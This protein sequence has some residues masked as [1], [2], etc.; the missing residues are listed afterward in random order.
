MNKLKTYSAKLKKTNLQII[1]ESITINLFQL[2][3]IIVP[4]INNGKILKRQNYLENHFQNSSLFEN[5]KNTVTNICHKKLKNHLQT[6]KK[7]YRYD[8]D[9]F[10]LLKTSNNE[11]IARPCLNE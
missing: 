1:I 6:M 5:Y 10:T 11:R 7:D 3:F 2:H 4:L 8:L 9:G